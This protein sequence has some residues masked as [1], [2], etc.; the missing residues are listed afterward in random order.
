MGYTEGIYLSNLSRCVNTISLSELVMQKHTGALKTDHRLCDYTV[1]ANFLVTYRKIT[2][3]QFGRGK[4]KTPLLV[5]LGVELFL[6]V[7]M[8]F[9]L[10]IQPLLKSIKWD[11]TSSMQANL[12]ILKWNDS[13]SGHSWFFP[14]AIHET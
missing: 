13:D 3:A 6:P 7:D 2:S 1:S 12:N 11:K 4:K 5:N 14:T 8:S 10:I 9:N